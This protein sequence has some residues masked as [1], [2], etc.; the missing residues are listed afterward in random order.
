MYFEKINLVVNI[1]NIYFI[2]FNNIIGV[3]FKRNFK[4]AYSYLSKNLNF[5]NLAFLFL[6]FFMFLFFDKL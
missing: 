6:F 1:I 3:I 4:F 5:G 2:M